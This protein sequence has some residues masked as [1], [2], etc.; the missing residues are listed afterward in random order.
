MAPIQ[1]GRTPHPASALAWSFSVCGGVEHA[2]DVA[3]E[4]LGDAAVVVVG[5]FAPGV[6]EARRAVVGQTVA[7]MP[8]AIESVEAVGGHIARPGHPVQRE[9]LLGA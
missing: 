3:A 8:A 9:S 6:T 2:T 4:L 5:P 7:G 1:A